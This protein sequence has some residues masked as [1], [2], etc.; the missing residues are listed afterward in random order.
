MSDA[1]QLYDDYKARMTKIADVR[2]A[3][4]LL[5]WDQ[6]TYLPAKG[7][8]FR[9]QQISTLTEMAHEMFISNELGDLLNK[10]LQQNDLNDEERRNVERTQEDYSKSKK[11]TPAFVRAMSDQVNKTF[12][13]WMDA[14]KQNSF[15]VY[16]KDLST[17]VTLKK[18]GSRLA[19]L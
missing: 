17:V 18:T 16:E 6:E 4:G 2:N 13:A 14:R 8:G 19:R 10:L 11:Y 15:R 9:G 7:A 3:S 5:Q 1:R 12:H